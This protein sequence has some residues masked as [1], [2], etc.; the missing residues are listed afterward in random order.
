MTMFDDL[1]SD[2]GA[3]FGLGTQAAPLV[4]EMVQ[5]M[6]R[7]SGGLAG[8]IDKFNAAGL[9]P[10]AQAWLGKA[11]APPLAAAQIEQVLGTSTVHGIASRLGLGN[12]LVGNAIAFAMPK[13]IGSLTPAGQ[14]PVGVPA[15]I[16]E[17][18]GQ[19]ERV[20]PLRVD[21]VTEPEPARRA[22]E[23]FPWALPLVA[24]LA[25][26]GLLWYLLSGRPDRL[27]VAPQP[28]PQTPTAPAPTAQA[29]P[30]LWFSNEAGTL[31]VFGTVSDE[32]SRKT[33]LAALQAA[34]GADKLK[35]NI[36]ID[37]KAAPLAWLGQIKPL[38]EGLKVPG[39]QAII[40]NKAVGLGGVGESERVT[41]ATA[42]KTVL[43]PSIPIGPIGDQAQLWVAG[44]LARLKSRLQGL[45]DPAAAPSLLQGLS[46]VDGQVSGLG[47][48]VSYL[49]VDQKKIA[50]TAAAGAL[51]ALNAAFDKILTVPG[52]APAA[53][54]GIDDLRMKLDT[55]A[56]G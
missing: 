4:G 9:G 54:A 47:S 7:Q 44:A 41:I 18:L 31:S 10:Q 19:Y 33:L 2:I 16:T 26:G 46:E 17:F 34:F 23:R 13:L 27:A 28:A 36:S 15:A 51:P 40:D 35:A 52:L 38:I 20:A 14:I 43:G 12:S 49:S 32:A 5:I 25:L 3:R 29:E 37:A 21:V 48:M 39:L 53:K 30:H 11:D 24:I 1:V 22:A 42:W 55:L 50:A 45:A 56:R 8:L 6:A